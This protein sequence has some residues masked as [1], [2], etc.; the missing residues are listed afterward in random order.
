MPYHANAILTVE[1]P[2]KLLGNKKALLENKRVLEEISTDN[3]RILAERVAVNCPVEELHQ[4]NAMVTDISESNDENC[5][6]HYLSASCSLKEI[7]LSKPTPENKNPFSA[8]LDLEAGL[9]A[10]YENLIKKYLIDRDV[11]HTFALET[12]PELRSKVSRKIAIIFPV[13]KY[14]LS[15][16]IQTAFELLTA[17]ER[18]DKSNQLAAFF[19]NKAYTDSILAFSDLIEGK[20][21]DREKIIGRQFAALDPEVR[22]NINRTLELIQ[23]KAYDKESCFRKISQEMMRE[24][25]DLEP[26]SSSSNASVPLSPPKRANSNAFFEQQQRNI[27]VDDVVLCPF[28]CS[29]L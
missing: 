24:C 26:V 2:Y 20:L 13:G 21:S 16:G 28:P 7:L 6:Y 17:F 4:F 15:T 12:P 23:P 9:I 10:N 14:D 5:F 8:L 25:S 29:I 1:N 27:E 3:K 22:G 11:V 18:A 19:Q